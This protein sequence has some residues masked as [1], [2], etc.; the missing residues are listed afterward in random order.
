[1]YAV[2]HERQNLQIGKFHERL[3]IQKQKTCVDHQGKCLVF[4]I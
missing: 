4:S 1:M 3:Y 2:I